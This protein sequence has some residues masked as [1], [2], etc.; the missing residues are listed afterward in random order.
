MVYLNIAPESEPSFDI[1][2]QCN[3]VGEIELCL[4]VERTAV[5]KVVAVMECRTV[6]QH[7]L[8]PVDSLISGKS[9]YAAVEVES[10]G[11]VAEDMEIISSLACELRHRD[12]TF[13]A[14]WLEGLEILPADRPCIAVVPCKY[15]VE[16]SEIIAAFAGFAGIKTVCHIR[17][18][19]HG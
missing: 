4:Q 12:T 8:T 5:D 7:I 11:V 6:G 17:L 10:H 18:Y 16:H 3:L 1:G 15:G 19:F 9:G 2:S 13:L 14:V